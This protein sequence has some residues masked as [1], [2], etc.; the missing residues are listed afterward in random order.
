MS[1]SEVISTIASSILTLSKNKDVKKMVCGTY[2][3]G[4]V[5]SIYDTLNNEYVSP[6]SKKKIR[7]IVD[8][9]TLEETGKKKKSKKRKDKKKKKKFKKSKY[10][11]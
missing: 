1:V 7:K 10:R 4:K 6:K 8:K 2:T 3:D 11:F 5:R 9:I